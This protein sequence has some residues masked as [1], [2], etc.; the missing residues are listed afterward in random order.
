MTANPEPICRYCG[1]DEGLNLC[2]L[3]CSPCATGDT[4]MRYQLIGINKTT[5]ERKVFGT[6]ASLA[7]VK[8]WLISWDA[9]EGDRW[10]FRIERQR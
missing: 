9:T 8:R 4:T 10:A 2:T 6:A 7:T 5:S 1:G 3:V